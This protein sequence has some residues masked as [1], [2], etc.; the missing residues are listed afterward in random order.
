MKARAVFWMGMTFI[1]GHDHGSELKSGMKEVSEWPNGY[2]VHTRQGNVREIK[3]FSR[4][5]NCQGIS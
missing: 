2:R 3:N 5:G 1:R 4:S